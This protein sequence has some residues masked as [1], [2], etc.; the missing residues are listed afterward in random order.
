MAGFDTASKICYFAIARLVICVEYPK[1]IKKL[2][3]NRIYPQKIYGF[4][5]VNQNSKDQ[6]NP[7]KNIA[8]GMFAAA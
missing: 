8:V 6:I 4:Q 2:G 7:R 5:A 3:F 1:I